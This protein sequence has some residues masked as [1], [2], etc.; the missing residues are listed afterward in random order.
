MARKKNRVAVVGVGYSTVGRG[1]GL[2][3]RQLAAQ[4]AK[5]ALADAG[6]TPKDIDGVCMHSG[7]AGPEPEG[8]DAVNAVDAG[9]MLGITPLNWFCSD[10]VAPAF[11]HTAIHAIAAITAGL[12]HTVIAFR[13]IGQRLSTS[14]Q[15]AQAGQEPLRVRGDAQFT[16]PFGSL[17]GVQSIAGLAAPRYMEKYGITEEHFGMHVIAQRYHASLN[18]E[19]IF[20]TPLTMDDYLNS[21]YVS[22]PM[23]LLD[24][25]YPVDS[26]AAVIFTSEDR[27]Y[28]W[29]K[30]PVFVEAAALSA[31]SYLSFENLPDPNHA[32]PVHAANMLWSRTDLKPKDVSCAQLYDGFT[33]IVFHWLEA[34]GFCGE[35]EAGPFIA[36]GHTR[37]G[38]SLPVNTDGGACNVGRR[39]GANFCIEAVRQL[40]GECGPRQVPDARV[41]VW[42]NST[43][44]FS[45]VVLMTR[46]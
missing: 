9:A 17:A 30:K 19:A 29:K 28:D 24:C 7:I 10:I 25:D 42:A 37:L 23:R 27:A 20:R 21:R 13:V 8:W 22:K 31:I 39:H 40:R 5:A 44:P 6:M 2:S 33:I 16:A 11:V 45:G 41:A 43:G 18:P 35:G 34:L 1:T 32:S 46:D 26:G 3:G 38:G 36:A 12:C 15:M 4:A 14:Q